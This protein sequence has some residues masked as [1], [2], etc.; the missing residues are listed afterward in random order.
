MNGSETSVI[1]EGRGVV[2]RY[3]PFTA[4]DGVDF[5]VIRGEC[6]GFLGPN[7]AGKTSVM[8][9]IQC[10]SPVS[11]GSIKIA[12][13]SAGKDDSE[14]KAIVGVAPQEDSLD[15]DLSVAQNLIVFAGYFGIPHKLAAERTEKLLD[16][17]HLEEWRNKK[18]FALSGGMKRRLVIARALINEPRILILDEPTTG[19]DPSARLVIWRKLADLKRSGVTMILTTHYME[20]AARL[21]DRIAIMKEGRILLSG[22][23][24][25][26]IETEFGGTVT[27]FT[28]AE[29]LDTSAAKALETTGVKYERVE[30]SFVIFG[31]PEWLDSDWL[32]KNIGSCRITTRT[33]NLEDLFIKMTHKS[34][35][36]SGRMAVR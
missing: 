22:V 18:L 4:V 5:S 14:I 24:D 36:S 11:S 8:R 6:F 34:S 27:E 13:L 17:F 12:G 2:K 19:L 23:P 21:C 30:N 31:A 25:K 33:A 20:E 28:C 9:M 35:E 15:D 1:V 29:G 3:G 26:L 7:G 10:L 32:E 16:F